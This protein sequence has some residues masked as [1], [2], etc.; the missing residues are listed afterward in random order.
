MAKKSL[1]GQILSLD[2]HFL[3]AALTP[4][5]AGLSPAFLL[6][7][8]SFNPAQVVVSLLPGDGIKRETLAFM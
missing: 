1:V 4:L 5:T 2:I 8:R 7:E 3:F 6:A